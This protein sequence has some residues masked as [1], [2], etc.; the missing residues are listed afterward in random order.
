MKKLLLVVMMALL[1]IPVFAQNEGKSESVVN[2]KT[3]TFTRGK[4]FFARPDFYG[5]FFLNGGYQFNPYVQ[6]SLGAG[7]SLIQINSNQLGGVFAAHAGAR[8]YTGEKKWAAM[9]DFHSGVFNYAGYTFFR[10][11]IVAGASYKDLD[12]G[13]GLAYISIP[14]QGAG[15][16]LLITLGWNVRFY[17]HR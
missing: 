5:G 9:F 16:G 14:N 12:F 7:I 15:L 13:P 8:V 2:Q 10:H 1:A 3:N 11:S 6:A 17:P 4:G